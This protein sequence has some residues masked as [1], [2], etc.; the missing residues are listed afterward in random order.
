[1]KGNLTDLQM[2]DQCSDWK[3]A[4]NGA[5]VSDGFGEKDRPVLFG[6]DPCVATAT[7]V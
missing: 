4:E 5:W 2:L 3:Q 7:G 6:P 1:M